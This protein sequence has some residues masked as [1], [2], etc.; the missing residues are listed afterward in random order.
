MR[1]LAAVKKVAL[2]T[3]QTGTNWVKH[4]LSKES[5]EDIENDVYTER[6]PLEDFSNVLAAL[7]FGAITDFV[8]MI[9]RSQVSSQLYDIIPW[10]FE[11]TVEGPPLNGSFQCTFS[12]SLW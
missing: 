6:D 10:S 11:C 3:L 5:A 9:R 12:Y 7:K 1:I 4:S 2:R 8:G